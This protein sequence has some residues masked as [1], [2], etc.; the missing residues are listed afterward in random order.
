MKRVFL[1]L[2]TTFI[3]FNIAAIISILKR[4][5]WD[6]DFDLTLKIHYEVSVYA[7]KCGC[8]GVIV[9]WISKDWFK[10]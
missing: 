5:G 4:Q 9:D 2:F 3:S 1:I 8:I 10:K 7:L 6:V